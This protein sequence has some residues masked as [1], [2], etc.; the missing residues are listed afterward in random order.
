[1]CQGLCD[2]NSRRV[3]STKQAFLLPDILT[4]RARPRW[5]GIL[6][7]CRV[8]HVTPLPSITTPPYTHFLLLQVRNQGLREGY[9]CALD[10]TISD[11][12]RRKLQASWLVKICFFAC[13]ALP[14]SR[15]L[16]ALRFT[17]LIAVRMRNLPAGWAMYKLGVHKQGAASAYLLDNCLQHRL[18]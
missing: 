6:P 2:Y 3:G 12:T 15:S 1:M 4:Q 9:H 5:V 8:P 11:R 17:T 18:I 13:I 10:H 14:P 7:V 16:K